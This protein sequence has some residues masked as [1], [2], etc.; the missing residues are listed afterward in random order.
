MQLLPTS[1]SNWTRNILFSSLQFAEDIVFCF[2]L[3]WSSETFHWY[4]VLSQIPI[5]KRAVYQSDLLVAWS[6]S[7][8]AWC[9]GLLV[10]TRFNDLP[11][12]IGSNWSWLI[13]GQCWTGAIT[14][15][16]RTRAAT[17]GKSDRWIMQAIMTSSD[18]EARFKRFQLLH[19]D[20]LVVLD[21][22]SSV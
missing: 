9:S 20:S 22:V 5:R 12:E 14:R 11:A 19:Q 6:V 4:I 3:S 17:T 15:A 10:L 13:Q 21:T 16:T 7:P 18:G 8:R 2:F 1:S